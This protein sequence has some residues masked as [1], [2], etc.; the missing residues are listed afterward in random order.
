[1]K[2]KLNTKWQSWVKSSL[3]LLIEN[4]HHL[5]QTGLRSD[6]SVQKLHISPRCTKSEPKS[7]TLKTK[8]PLPQSPLYT[9]H[10]SSLDK[11]QLFTKSCD[12]PPAFMTLL[13]V[14]CHIQ[15]QTTTKGI[16]Q[17]IAADVKNWNF[18]LILQMQSSYNSSEF[19]LSGWQLFSNFFHHLFHWEKNFLFMEWNCSAVVQMAYYTKIVKNITN[20]IML[21]NNNSYNDAQIAT[22]LF[23][24]QYLKL[25]ARQKVALILCTGSTK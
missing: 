25:L 3:W 17:E 22:Q 2:T 1:M 6:W 24:W 15:R 9:R 19:S 13:V 10:M 18:V 8:P 5:L 20:F 14:Y 7:T 4:N 11:V 23:Y 21:K 12:L 16:F